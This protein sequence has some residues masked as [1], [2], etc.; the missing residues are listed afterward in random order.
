MC[1]RAEQLMRNLERKR[2]EAHKEAAEREEQL[3]QMLVQQMT[4]D[5]RLEA[6]GAPLAGGRILY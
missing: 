2:E 5:Q 4:P 1:T 3:L 6:T